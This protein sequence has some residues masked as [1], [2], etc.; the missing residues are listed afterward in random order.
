VVFSPDGSL[1]AT[2][3]RDRTV[4]LWDIK[5]EQQVAVLRGHAGRVYDVSFKPDGRLLASASRDKTA[6]LW[7]V[8]RADDDG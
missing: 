8:E 3:S 1:L 6:R 4:R 5:A 7:G 2:S